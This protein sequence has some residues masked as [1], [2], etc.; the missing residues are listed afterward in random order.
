M[1]D[2]LFEVL[3]GTDILT[4][5]KIWHAYKNNPD[6]IKADEKLGKLIKQFRE[7]FGQ[8]KSDE[9]ESTFLGVL[10]VV[11]E[12]VYKK[13]LRDGYISTMKDIFSEKQEEIKV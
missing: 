2:L 7:D 11:E 5:G 9:I 8:E 12:C 10:S 6:Y 13:G 3:K 4:N 1:V